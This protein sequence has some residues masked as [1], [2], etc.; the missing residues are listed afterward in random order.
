MRTEIS[1]ISKSALADPGFNLVKGGGQNFF[2]DFADVVKQS[3]ASEVSQYWRGSRARLRALEA[4]AFLTLKH[5]FS[6]FSMYFF[7]KIFYVPLCG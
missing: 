7:F 4:L 5:A 1:K 3:R 6:N 2:R